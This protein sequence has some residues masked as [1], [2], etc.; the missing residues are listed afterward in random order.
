MTDPTQDVFE[1]VLLRGSRAGLPGLVHLTWRAPSQGDRLVQVHVDGVWHTA[2]ASSAERAMWLWL[3]PSV[4]HR[5]E[6]LAVDASAVLT[7]FADRLAGWSP[8]FETAAGVTIVRHES[9]DVD[10]TV[11][12]TVNGELDHAAPLWR[13]DDHRSGFGGLLGIGRFGH[14]DATA[15]GFALGD[16]GAGGFGSDASPWR[17]RR[18]DLPAGDHLIDAAVT[19]RFG[20]T[21]ATLNPP[22]STTVAA[23]P[24][25]ARH[26][27]ID[28]DFTIRWEA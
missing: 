21:I 8:A 2:T 26:F 11:R 9:L 19:D 13:G 27:T 16:L 28:T 3:N 25:P 15:P 18:D 6:L 4:P 5:V 1:A 20:R 7:D 10:A 22:A 23:L 12:V 24:T 14:D 17:W